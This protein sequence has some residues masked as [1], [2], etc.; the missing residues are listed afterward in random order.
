MLK[1]TL[2][3]FLIPDGTIIDYCERA[4]D[5]LAEQFKDGKIFKDLICT[6]TDEVQEIEYVLQDLI[7]FRTV[8]TAYGAQLDVIGEIV[9][10]ARSGLTDSNYRNAIKTKIFINVSNGESETII[11]YLTFI[12][13]A[14]TVTLNQSYPAGVNLFTDGLGLN[15]NTVRLVEQ[16]APAGVK[17]EITGSFGSEKIFTLDA[18]AG[19]VSPPKAFGFS[20]PTVID[21]GGS[22]TEKFT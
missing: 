12:T 7:V 5:R 6:L 18:D 22:L 3:V 19:T 8:E 1:R 10:I 11:T 16:V 20:E 4:V 15:S 2:K 9:G 21:S 14:T 17:I 13:N